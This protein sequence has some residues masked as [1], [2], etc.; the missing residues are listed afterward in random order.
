M[1]LYLTLSDRYTL[2]GLL[3]STGS[4]ATM[5]E[6]KAAQSVLL[7]SLAEER[8]LGIKANDRGLQWDPKK[9][10][11][12][13]VE[14]SQFMVLECKATLMKLEEDKKVTIP[15]LS[16]WDQLVEGKIPTGA[17]V[18]TKGTHDGDGN[19]NQRPVQKGTQRPPAKVAKSPAIRAG[20]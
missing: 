5:R 9:D 19:Q 16:L 3:P 20:D 1:T 10:K 2:I 14:L 8:D 7:P 13:P 4:Q 12:K 11:L 6:V 18:N 15:H 17:P